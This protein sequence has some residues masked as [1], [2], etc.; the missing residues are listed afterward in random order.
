[1]Q[2]YDEEEPAEVEVK[3]LV[4][5]HQCSGDNLRSTHRGVNNTYPRR[6]GGGGSADNLWWGNVKKEKKKRI[7]EKEKGRQMNNKDRRCGSLKVKIY[8]L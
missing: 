7:N 8:G 1:V 4:A 2:A 5:G 6:H 3:K